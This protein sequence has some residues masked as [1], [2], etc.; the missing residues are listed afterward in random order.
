MSCLNVFTLL[1]SFLYNIY[2][3]FYNIYKG[4]LSQQLIRKLKELVFN[5]FLVSA[6]FVLLIH[7][8]LAWMRYFSKQALQCSAS[9]PSRSHKKLY[10]IVQIISP[11]RGCL[12]I[13]L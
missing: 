4:F 7:S 13:D 6:Y 10:V 1:L 8:Q 5:V 9:V 2:N 11:A 3:I 12:S